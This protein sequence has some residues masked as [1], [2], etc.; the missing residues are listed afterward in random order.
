MG[1]AKI[2]QASTTS[3]LNQILAGTVANVASGYLI[4]AQS[5]GLSPNT[6]RGYGNEIRALLAWLDFQGVISIEEMSADVI[7]KY[8]LSLKE[9]RNP[10]GQAAGYRLIRQLTFWW[11]RETDD[12][13]KLPIRKVKPPKVNNQPLPG[14]KREAIEAMLDVCSGPTRERDRAVM[15]FLAD[16]GVRASELTDLKMSDIDLVKGSAVIRHGKGGKRRVVY[17]GQKTRRELRKYLAQRK[18]AG[19][20]DALFARDDGDPLTF[21]GLRQIVRRRA[22]MAGL[23]EPGLHD[24]RRFFALNMLRNGADLISLARLMGHS[25]ITVL[26]RYLYQ[27]DADLQAIHAKASPLDRS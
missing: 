1:T 18:H 2:D 26:Q 6:L 15:L 21:A 13:Y 24:F 17:F 23:P 10:G 11:E 19:V 9:H 20:E 16:T 3:V 22:A 12:E 14:I 27:V 4:D 25:G 7:R 8:L 5:R